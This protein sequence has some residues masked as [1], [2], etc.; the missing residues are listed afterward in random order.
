[1]KTEEV[2][3]ALQQVAA[4]VVTPRF[5]R[6]T[7]GDVMEKQPGDLVTVAD[8]EAELA[9]ADIL[10]KAYPTALVVGEEAT[11]ADPALVTRLAGSD[12]SFVLDPIDGTRNFVA[13][14]R[15][16]AAMLAEVRRG[17]VTRAWIWQPAHGR[18]IVAEHGA[19]AW[20]DGRR[21][22]AR[23]TSGDPSALRVCTSRRAW[24]GS[25][26]RVTVTSSAW[27]CG[28][29]YPN[30]ASGEVDAVLFARG[31][32]WDHAPGLLILQETGG[33]ITTWDGTPYRADRP[34]PGRLLAA[35][36]EQCRQLLVEHLAPLLRAGSSR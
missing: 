15:D 27:C 24:E 29:D 11:A 35:A 9:I 5:G 16:H 8:R 32:P 1:M 20:M 31:Q 22:P 10:R 6:L 2:L 28:V 13:G 34:S 25:H 12:H 33:V 14:S 26:A 3:E 7:D 18:A 36:S 30:V 19:G 21:L 4:D 23:Q 17:E